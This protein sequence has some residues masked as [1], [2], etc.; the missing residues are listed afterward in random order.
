M[1]F[2]LDLQLLTIT[3]PCS[4]KSQFT[5]PVTSIQLPVA[6]RLW[7]QAAGSHR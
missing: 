1:A 7:G 6:S 3:I 2:N 4:L 5:T